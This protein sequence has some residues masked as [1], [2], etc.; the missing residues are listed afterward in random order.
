MSNFCSYKTATVSIQGISA[1]ME[2]AMR[3]RQG[4]PRH[5]LLPDMSMTF[6]KK[7]SPLKL[8]KKIYE[9]YTAPITKFWA[10]TVKFTTNGFVKTL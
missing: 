2:D 8:G 5:P 7:T 1:M 10:H 3:G 6:K 9:F 4:A